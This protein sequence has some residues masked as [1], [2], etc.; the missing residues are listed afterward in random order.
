MVARPPAD[1][2]TVTWIGHSTVLLQM[3]NVCVLTDPMFSD[4][5]GPVRLPR[6]A[7]RY[8]RPACTVNELPHVD[9]VVISHNHYDHLDHE[10]VL[11]LNRR[12]GPRLCWFVPAG[13]RTWMHSAGCQNVVELSWWDE[14]EFV[15]EGT[16]APVKFVCVP[17]QHWSKRTVWDDNKVQCERPCIP[18]TAA[19]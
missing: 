15:K 12:Y 16:D 19:H 2:L 3:D 5:C 17:A 13:L 10:S 7:R 1:G 18:A 14:H 9:A 8:R 4:S 6:V 11:Q